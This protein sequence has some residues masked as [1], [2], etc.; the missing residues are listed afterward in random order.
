MRHSKVRFSSSDHY[1]VAPNP[2]D[3]G[4]ASYDA[5]LPVVGLMFA[6]TRR[7]HLYATAGRGFETPTLNELAYRPSGAHRA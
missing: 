3:S 4:S 7:V 1:I 2:D 6:A 5:T